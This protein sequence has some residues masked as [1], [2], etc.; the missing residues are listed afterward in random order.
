MAG[1]AFAKPFCK[2][3]I[4]WSGISERRSAKPI[5]GRGWLC[6]STSEELTTTLKVE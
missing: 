3:S 5:N 4:S 1:A 2:R 6:P